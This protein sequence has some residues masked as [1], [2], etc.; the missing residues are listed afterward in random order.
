LDSNYYVI[1]EGLNEMTN[2][3]YHIPPDRSGKHYLAPCLYSHAP[4]D[5]AILALGGND[6]KVYFNRSFMDIKKGSL[7]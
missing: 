7:S 4:I 3:D 6:I 5:L 1:E 2:I